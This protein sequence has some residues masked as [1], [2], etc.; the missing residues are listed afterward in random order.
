MPAA[1]I[2]GLSEKI[3]SLRRPQATEVFYSCSQQE[4]DVLCQQTLVDRTRAAA[5]RTLIKKSK[6]GVLHETAKGEPAQVKC[7]GCKPGTKSE[8]FPCYLKA[9]STAVTCGHCNYHKRSKC[10]AQRAPTGSFNDLAFSPIF[11][12]IDESGVIA[13]YDPLLAPAAA[14]VEMTYL[15][16]LQAEYNAELARLNHEVDMGWYQQ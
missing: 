9:N 3:R 1:H 2:P 7:S 10:D 15:E 8:G 4:W 11:T 5:T 14:P 12:T 16:W 13:P 6:A